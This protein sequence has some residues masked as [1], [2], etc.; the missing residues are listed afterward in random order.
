MFS[1]LHK[2]EQGTTYLSRETNV[3]FTTYFRGISFKIGLMTKH[4]RF[5]DLLNSKACNRRVTYL[6]LKIIRGLRSWARSCCRWHGQ[7]IHLC[8]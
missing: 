6:T 5:L 7:T 1:L 4:D 3:I 2:L 8:E